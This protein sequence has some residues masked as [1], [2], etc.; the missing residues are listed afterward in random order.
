[1]VLPWTFMM[2]TPE[3][4]II[5]LINERVVGHSLSQIHVTNIATAGSRF[6][7]L[8]TE[9]ALPKERAMAQVT[10]DL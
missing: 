4:S 3:S 2:R 9:L 1:M 10:R 7:I 5:P 6:I 8:A